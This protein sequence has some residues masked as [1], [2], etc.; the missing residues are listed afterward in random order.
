[1]IH[2]SWDSTASAD[3]YEVWRG[4]NADVTAGEPLETNA[5]SSLQFGDDTTRAGTTYSYWVRG[6]NQAGPGAFSAPAQAS[7]TNQFWRAPYGDFSPEVAGDGTVYEGVIR[8]VPWPGPP[9]GGIIAYSE[10]GSQLWVYR[11]EE[12]VVGTPALAPDGRIVF[13]TPSLG[14]GAAVK[15]LDGDGR[16]I[17]SSLLT[18]ELWQDVC[19]DAYGTAWV[20]SDHV[21][22]GMGFLYLDALSSDGVLLWSQP[23]QGSID[24][25]LGAHVAIGQDGTGYTVSGSVLEAF[26]PNGDIRWTSASLP[27]LRAGLPP[28]FNQNGELLF[29]GPWYERFSPDESLV[30]S[31]RLAGLAWTYQ[32]EPV[33]GADGRAYFATF[34]AVACVDTNGLIC[35]TNH[36]DSLTAG[37]SYACV[38]VL[39][40][41]GNIYV[42]VTGAVAILDHDGALIEQLELA[43]LPDAPLV[44]TADGRLYVPTD[45]GLYS[46]RAL[47]G[48]DTSAPWPMYRHDPAGT[49]SVQG[50]LQAPAPPVLLA[51]TPYANRVRIP[52]RAT[53]VPAALELFRGTTTNFE[54]ATLVATGRSGE[55]FADDTNTVPGVTY[56]YWACLENAGGTSTLS[57]PVEA[58]AVDV[59]VKWFA[60]VPGLTANPPAIAPDG[61]IYTCGTN[62][63]LALN[64]DGAV[65]WQIPG[66]TGSPVLSPGNAIILRAAGQLYSLSSAGATNW[67]VEDLT[68][69]ASLLPAV[70]E[71]GTVVF[72]PADTELMAVSADG[73][74]LWRTNYDNYSLTT[75]SI[76]ADGSIVLV[77]DG[78]GIIRLNAD[79]TESFVVDAPEY[80]RTSLAPVLDSEGTAYLPCGT[81][82]SL[83]A[84]LSD[85][86]NKWQLPSS[87]N[88]QTPPVVGPDGEV[89]AAYITY[90]Y[91]WLTVHQYLAA[92]APDGSLSWTLAI[93]ETNQASLALSSDGVLFAT[94]GTTLF[95]LSADDGQ[96]LWQMPSPNGQVFGAPVLDYDGTLYLPVTN[97]LLALQLKAGPAASAWPMYRQNPRQSACIQRL[98]A[99]Q[100]HVA[101]SSTRQPEL[102]LL[103]PGGAIILRS[104]D[105]QAWQHD[106]FQSA[107][108]GPVL[109]PIDPGGQSASFFLVLPP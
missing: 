107:T 89:Y 25:P 100:A 53:S 60:S 41:A 109:W 67:V 108:T 92:I 94:A 75:P 102:Q 59:P 31:N 17:W 103:A 87:Q 39:D 13:Q 98:T 66:L 18:T 1:M 14:G 88:I 28:V 23:L 2:L 93:G 101:W 21:A 63:L 36:L 45:G 69:W 27:V 82:R 72:N 16:L 48:L 61:A 79:G 83:S 96:I 91:T 90:V 9:Q 24:L 37:G 30:A 6:V 42:P 20:I 86:T 73:T 46:F 77:R 62:S 12:S 29:G 97:G 56:F 3:S 54:D 33:V 74:T 32:T 78:R 71:D 68:S 47:A 106:G 99:P 70:G 38:P 7:Q 84:V 5:A 80:Y 52:C 105:L 81:P 15:S 26:Y 65:R 11:D 50:P 85:G 55:L 95:A 4:T 22:G 104:R 76:G 58:A 35:W 10:D 34:K 49:A 64:T 51:P 57:G 43:H 44:L 19:V 40:K 8:L